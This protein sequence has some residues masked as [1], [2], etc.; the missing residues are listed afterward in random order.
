MKSEM[1]YSG[2]TLVGNDIIR[3]IDIHVNASISYS[4]KEEDIKNALINFLTR[5]LI[6]DSAFAEYKDSIASY[7]TQF[8]EDEAN[9]TMFLDMISNSISG[10]DD[11]T[12]TSDILKNVYRLN[13]LSSNYQLWK[14][15]RSGF[16]DF[17][18]DDK[19]NNTVLEQKKTKELFSGMTDEQKKY[20]R[21]L[22]TSQ[23]Y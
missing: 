18:E 4:L 7:A 11:L 9:V 1:K 12:I 13:I 3:D 10:I 15:M 14:T 20:M 22:L 19:L 2:R 23:G 17:I 5:T 16:L 6:K 8:V 21:T